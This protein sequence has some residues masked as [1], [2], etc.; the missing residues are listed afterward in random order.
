[1]FRRNA[2][3]AA[4]LLLILLTATTLGAQ[5]TTPVQAGPKPLTAEAMAAWKSL[6]GTA[7]SYDGAWFAYTVV[8][9]EG[10]G[11]VVIRATA[12]DKE[13]RFPTGD[14][15]QATQL[16]ISGDSRWAA[17]LA[18]PTFKDSKKLRKEKK[19]VQ[20][21][22]VLLNLATGEKREVEKI[23]RIV[24]AGEKPTW[25]ALHTAT[26]APA[27][28][29]P[30][31][32]AAAPTAPAIAATAVILHDLA[33]NSSLTIA[34]VGEF[35][36]DWSG[37][38]LAYTVETASRVGNGVQLRNMKSE[39]VRAADNSK[40]LYRRLTWADSGMALAVYRGIPDSANTDTLYALVT[41]KNFAAGAPTRA[42]WEPSAATG[43]PIKMKIAADRAPRWTQDFN[44]VYLG[45][46]DVNPPKPKGPEWEDDEKPLVEIWHG[47]DPRLQ[48]QQKVQESADKSFNYLSVYW[49]PTQRF[50]QL[51]T[52][53]VRTVTPA[54][55]DRWA[56]GY[57]DRA[58]EL[59]ASLSG[60]RKR[61]AYVIDLTN[62][63]R[64]KVLSVTTASLS[65]STDGQRFAYMEDGHYFVQE[66]AGGASRNLTAGV[67]A[68]FWNDEDDHNVVKPPRFPVGWSAD[69]LTL[70]LTDG[71]DIWRFPV[72]GGA[73]VNL[74][75]T[76]KRDGVASP[77]PRQ[78]LPAARLR[79]D[80]AADGR[81]LWRMDQE[82]RPRQG[83]SRK[84]WRHVTHL[85]GRGHSR[86]ARP[87]RRGLPLQQG[88]LP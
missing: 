75:V 60:V 55:M 77:D 20:A 80:Q 11:E 19:P 58:F 45:I 13:Y 24:F 23:R 14:G 16:T 62:G 63:S 42:V 21:T 74:T 1:M 67:N 9:G 50:V 54:P 69:G 37:E 32:G 88:H 64:R 10:D 17:W 5:Q 76:G 72:R 2:R 52:D 43:F 40:G 4:T 82:G 56:V 46:R 59:E 30:V 79:P 18:W 71:W 61:D 25:V 78:Q 66:F 6:R 33:N 41:W 28:A 39:V 83:R 36:F 65:P 53:E 68:T 31:P 29:A 47:K 22:A 8:P 15:S 7:T 70:L 48:P 86:H 34:D 51:A 26:D 81:D 73:P 57:D 35:G 3:F 44:G 85:G 27:P 38:W 12:S 87:R 84:A 49:L